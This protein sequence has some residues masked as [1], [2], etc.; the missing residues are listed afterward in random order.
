MNN[1]AGANINNTGFTTDLVLSC[2]SAGLF[3]LGNAGPYKTYAN[4]DTESKLDVRGTSL[5][6]SADYDNFSVKSITAWRDTQYDVKRDADNTPLTILHSENHDKITQ[7]SQEIQFTGDAFDDCA[8]WVAGLYYF[9]ES[10]DFENPVF[11]P[12]LTVGALT[13]SGKLETTNLAAFGQLTYDITDVLNVTV[14]VRGTKEKKLA[15][16][17]FYAIGNYNVPNPFST[18][19]LRCGG[20]G[21]VS[22]NDATQAIN[23]P[24]AHCIKLSDGDP[25][26]SK[27]ENE[28]NFSQFTPMITVAYDLDNDDIIY[29]SHSEGFKSGGYS[30]R[31][32][33]PVPS[34]ANPDGVSLLPSFEPEEAITIEFGYKSLYENFKFSSALFSTQYKNQHVVVRQGVAPITFNAGESTIQGFEVEGSWTPT[35]NWYVTGSLGYV[36]GEYDSFNGL[37][38]DR[39]NTTLVAFKAGTGPA[40]ENVAGLV[41]LKDELAYTPK[42]TAS[43]GISYLLDTSMGRFTPRLDWSYRGK[44]YYDAANSEA[45]AQD[46]LSLLNLAVTWKSVNEDWKATFAIKNLT[47]ELYVTGGNISFSGSA[48][49]ES[50][51]ARPREWSLVVKRNF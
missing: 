35:S 51:Y 22:I 25:L 40:P 27:T 37:L 30:T 48:Y 20:P 43:L 9:K 33:Q 16:P 50:A 3:D 28:L 29:V 31:I 23:R 7:V 24:D 4:G 8:S 49:A 14:G 36:K 26:Y 45:I 13:N 10:T 41:D 21:L 44:V 5:T 19:G 39:Y 11:L 32:I 17:D 46:S 2:G 6:L 34:A 12:A 1:S 42:V 47:D 15:T 38:A 18:V